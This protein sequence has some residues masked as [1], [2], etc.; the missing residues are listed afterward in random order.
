MAQAPDLS[1]HDYI[2]L[3]QERGRY[4][5][6]REEAEASTGVRGAALSKALQRA[7]KAKRIESIR[8]GIYGIIP[9]EHR[10][11]GG[12]PADWY[13]DGLMDHLGMPYYV[14][15]LSAAALH[16]AAHQQPQ[17]FHVVL[18]EPLRSLQTAR[19]RVVFLRNSHFAEALTERRKTYTGTIRISTAEWTALDLLRYQQRI[20]GLDTAATVL[21]ELA[22][23]IRSDRLLA[24]CQRDPKRSYGQRLGWL[25]CSLGYTDLT[26]PLADWMMREKPSKV[27]LDPREPVRGGQLD[28]TWQV[29]VNAAP[30]AEI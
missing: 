13:I 6:T 21:T 4:L 20:G 24:A 29:V 7:T 2:D 27:R 3:L 19:S 26:A 23:E 25:L 22:E 5:F 17:V 12:V 14:G 18:P 28:S 16:G 10:A 1:L 9:L 15:V 30:E 11:A 8:Q